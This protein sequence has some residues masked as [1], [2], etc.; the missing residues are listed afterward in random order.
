MFT[1]NL[2]GAIQ[3]AA[4]NAD[5]RIHK[6][7]TKQAARSG[8]YYRIRCAGIIGSPGTASYGTA[9]Q[10]TIVWGDSPSPAPIVFVAEVMAALRQMSIITG[11]GLV[12]FFE[13]RVRGHGGG[14]DQAPD[15]PVDG[16]AI[17]VIDPDTVG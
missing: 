4:S 2:A 14:S 12:A 6:A 8:R 3:L 15:A 1:D 5:S 17:T 16:M 9:W 13:Q 7:D 10:I 11:P